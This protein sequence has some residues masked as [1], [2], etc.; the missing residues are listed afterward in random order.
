M[1]LSDFELERIAFEFRYAP[2]YLHFDRAGALWTEATE[3]WP[4]LKPERSEPTVTTFHLDNHHEFSVTI[5]KTHVVSHYPN[6]EEF[7]QLCEPFTELVTRNLGVLYFS[8]IGL[9]HVYFRKFPSKE[10]ASAAVLSTRM[11]SIPEGHATPPSNERRHFGVE[12]SSL[13]PEYALRAD[14]QGTGFVLRLRSEVRKIDFDPPMNMR[15]INALHE[16]KAGI[17][18]DIDYYTT[19]KVSIGQFRAQEWLN[20]AIHLVRRDSRQFLGGP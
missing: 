2:A 3:R 10:E 9:R 20:Q 1:E 19:A 15:Q 14:G 13:Y 12:L 18:F 11:L 5:D 6:V 7:V 4:N 16:T 8:R 17:L